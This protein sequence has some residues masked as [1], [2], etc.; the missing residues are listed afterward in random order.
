MELTSEISAE[1]LPQS[2]REGSL[3][4]LV[5]SDPG[6]SGMLGGLGA[7][8]GGASLRDLSEEELTE[9]L[10][11]ILLE[12]IRDGNKEALFQLGQLYFEEVSTIL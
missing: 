2:S 1:Q 12:K 6:L 8:P 3:L 9:K 4:S 7:G 10:E 11:N 5:Q